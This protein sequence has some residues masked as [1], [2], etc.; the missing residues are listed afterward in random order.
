MPSP[1]VPPPNAKSDH[2]TFATYLLRARSWV[3]LLL[4]ASVGLALRV[5]A[6]DRLPPGLFGDEAVEGLD[7]LDILA[8]NLGLWFHA[9][10]GR[11][12]LFVY[13]VALS[14]KALGISPLATRVPA[15]VAGFLTIPATFFVARE[16]AMST[17]TR[18]R[19]IRLALV[20]T[21]LV[22][23][24]FWHLQ[25]TR[26][27]HRVIL[28]PLVE[29]VGF[30]LL[31]RS[32]RTSNPLALAGA[33][34][35]LG[36]AIY[37]YSPGRF[38]PVLVVTFVAIEL[39]AHYM[40]FRSA[41]PEIRWNWKGLVAGG[42][43]A[44]VVMLPLGLYFLQNPVQFSRRFESVSV[45]DAQSPFEAFGTSVVG[46]LAQFVVPGSG[47]Q[48]KH[49][50]LPGKP[51]FDFF[52]AP[53]ALAGLGIC[54]TRLKQSPYRFLTL[55]FIVM[56]T[57][58][59]LTADMIPKAVR[60]LGVVPGVFIFPALALEGLWER[61]RDSWRP[62]AV[63]LVAVSLAGTAGLT[64]YDY[65]Y[66]WARMPELPAAFDADMVELSQYVHTQAQ[67]HPIYVSTEVY[68]HP[69]VMLLA[70]QVPTTQYF[71]RSV[72]IREFSARAGVV[73]Q[74][75]QA[76]AIYVFA[77]GQEPD[78]AWLTRAAPGAKQVAQGLYYRAYTLGG[79][80]VPQ[81]SLD[82]SFNPWL[83]LVGYS[84]YA[85]EPQGVALYWQ[86]VQLPPD[87]AETQTTITL[88]DGVGSSVTQGQ[89]ALSVPPM[90]WGL[91]DTIVDW[92]PLE[93]PGSTSQ[94]NVQLVRNKASAT[95]PE[96]D[97]K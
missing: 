73:W 93:I 41:V 29:A 3:V 92:Y 86:V 19:S 82:L 2:V 28:L 68:R 72:G 13:L 34:A 37:T 64:V 7:A 21:L 33:G 32:L 49:Y 60:G 24:S 66:T 12:P 53:W 74:P 51:I 17:M 31:W 59:F 80:Q 39:A 90:E 15:V 47:Y 85:D 52:M 16:W 75:G 83:R 46:N 89:H 11:E 6:I 65:F 5:Y 10:L 63:G 56:L 30:G 62:A 79:L 43:L 84:R 76:D 48:S 36:L 4:I 22:S 96:V 97:W 14:Y 1:T 71:D 26:D 35:V 67:H 8:G 42:A 54:L 95:S 50:N 78:E 94:F 87:R 9:H 88:Q 45:F 77:H 38:V 69:T 20:T 23:I 61:A 91:G 40:R 18:E 44:V 57:P 70:K 25:M 81:Q 58:S 55:W 27:A